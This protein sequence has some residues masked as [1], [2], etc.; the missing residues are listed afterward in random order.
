MS[1]ATSEFR[2]RVRANKTVWAAGAYDAMSAM[3][4]DAAGFDALGT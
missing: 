1:Q 3:M 2:N 4:I